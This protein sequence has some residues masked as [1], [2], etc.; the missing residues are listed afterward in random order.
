MNQLKKTDVWVEIMSCK[1]LCSYVYDIDKNKTNIVEKQSLYCF[2]EEE[3]KEL[4]NAA[5]DE[6]M[7]SGPSPNRNKFINNLFKPTTN[8]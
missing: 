1:K 2:T 8:E 3:L 6:S 7:E 5:F 4:I